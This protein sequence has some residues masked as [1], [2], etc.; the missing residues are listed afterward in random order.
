MKKDFNHVS[1]GIN[2]YYFSNWGLGLD[3]YRVYDSFTEDHI[4]SV[5]QLS[6]VFFNVTLTYWKKGVYGD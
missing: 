1:L 6:F 5:T 2:R 3:F 4:A